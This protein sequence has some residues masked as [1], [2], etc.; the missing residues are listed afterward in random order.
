MILSSNDKNELLKRL[1]NLKLSYENIHKKVS[2]DLYF[3]IPKGKKHLVWFTYFE[4]KRVCV[5]IQLN[6]GTQ[7]TITELFIVPQIFEKKLVLGTIFYG[8][9]FSMNGRNFFTLENIHFYR[10]KNIESNNE[11]YK[12]SLV[13]NIFDNE[14]K[15]AIVTKIGICIGLPII[16]TSFENAISCAKQL[17][18]EIY[19]I[20][21]RN[22]DE[23][24]NLYNSTLY[25]SHNTTE[26][27]N[28]IFLVK[29]DLQ[30]DVYHLYVKD[31]HNSLENYD[32][33][34]IPDY[35]TSIMMNK[36]F[37]TI[38]EN[39]NLDALEESD[40][41]G[42][43]EDVR[44]DKFV[45][46]DKS[47][48]MECAFQRK[49]NTFVPVKIVERGMIESKTSLEIFIQS[50]EQTNVRK[51]L[52]RQPYNNNQQNSRQPYNN[53][54][55]HSRQPY[56]SNHNPSRQP[57]HNNQQNSRQPYNNNNQ[58]NN[59]NNQT[60]NHNNNNQSQ[61]YSSNHRGQ[62]K[63]Y[64]QHSQNNHYRQSFNQ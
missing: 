30:N 46:L 38:K 45:K 3:L 19:S 20:Q 60:N 18:Y 50:L 48:I 29:P 57:Y 26:C 43:F 17:P 31:K 49:T 16:E 5:F 6:P 28:K 27:D 32:L 41:E 55:Q 1:P 22:F 51:N 13:Q 21:Q 64:N 24:K 40:D 56:N 11:K 15:H 63:T 42:E 52:P 14:L 54:Q 47:V 59:N 36:I 53:N 25:K 34:A 8:T 12:L 39:D 44:E 33:A 62:R 7:K 35:K 4:D 58:T 61:T 23:N 9:L 2:S 37:R 10:G